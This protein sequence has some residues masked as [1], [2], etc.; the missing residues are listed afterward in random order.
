MSLAAN[1]ITRLVLIVS[2]IPKENELGPA[3]CMHFQLM[4][5]CGNSFADK[6]EMQNLS[7]QRN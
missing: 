7:A 2:E 6:Y 5:D 3:P 4:R 1:S